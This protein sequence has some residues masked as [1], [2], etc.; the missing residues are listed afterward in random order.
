MAKTKITIRKKE[1]WKCG[2][3]PTSFDC[4]DERDN[5]LAS[6]ANERLF[7]TE[8]GCF[9]HTDKSKNLLRHMKTKHQ[10]DDDSD[11]DKEANTS[12]SKDLLS[13]SSESE[14]EDEW[15]RQDPG[16]ILGQ[17]SDESAHRDKE[18]EKDTGLKETENKKD[19]YMV[20]IKPDERT[21]VCNT[22]LGRIIRQ[23]TTPRLPGVRGTFVGRLGP[24]IFAVGNKSTDAKGLPVDNPDKGESKVNE[25]ENIALCST[26]RKRKVNL[27]SCGIQTDSL[28]YT[29]TVKTETT[30][31]EGP[32]KIR[33]VEVKEAI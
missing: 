2:F 5:Y 13:G 19:D 31:R 28:L 26:C 20:T 14:S 24:E 4:K 6:C 33:I 23:K 15:K 30:Y 17:D 16:D 7:C 32:K 10:K 29:R 8:G 11:S 12:K 3:C 18:E 21:V 27:V 22:E 9:Y 25:K 1:Q